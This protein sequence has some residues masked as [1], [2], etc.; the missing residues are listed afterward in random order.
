MKMS[1][2]KTPKRSSGGGS[3]EPERSGISRQEEALSS[4]D[5]LEKPWKRSRSLRPD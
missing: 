2:Q 4:V 5:S 1:Q 3:K